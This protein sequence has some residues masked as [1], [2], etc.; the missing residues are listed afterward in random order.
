MDQEEKWAWATATR[1]PRTMGKSAKG[2]AGMAG[3][4]KEK[5]Q[6][7][8]L[9]GRLVPE[10]IYLSSQSTIIKQELI[11]GVRAKRPEPLDC[12]SHNGSVFLPLGYPARLWGGAREERLGNNR[13]V[14]QT[15][16]LPKG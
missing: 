1:S 16:V 10:S 9:R 14:E 13:V 5:S 8:Q 4:L 3:F 7:E 2:P 15:Q 6:K 12:S 11:L